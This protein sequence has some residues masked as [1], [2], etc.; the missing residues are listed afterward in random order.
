MQQEIDNLIHLSR[1]YGTNKDFVIASGGNS[2]FK[3]K[4]YLWITASGSFMGK[5]EESDLLK[6]S[7]EKLNEISSKT[8]NSDPQE[9]EKE[10]KN[11][12]VASIE[13]PG[14]SN[15]PSVE[16]SLHNLIEYSYIIHTHPTLV[17]GLLCSKQAEAKTK[18]LFQDKALYIEYTD[19]GYTLFKRI[20]QGIESYRQQHNHDP[21]L[22]F[23]QNHGLFV[24]AD[25]PNEIRQLYDEVM[26]SLEKQV[27][28]SPD[29]TE[30]P[31]NGNITDIL[32]AIRMM[33]SQDGLKVLKIRNNAL[34]ESY[35]QNEQAFKKISAPFTPDIIVF[36]KSHYLYINEEND[37]QK[38][39]QTFQKKLK[40]FQDAYGDIPKIILIKH[41]GIISVDEQARSAETV[42]DIYEDLIKISHYSEN[43]GGPNFM[44]KEQISFIENWEAEKYRHKLAKGTQQAASAK[45]QTAIVTGGSQG[46]GEGIV[47]RLFKKGINVVI[48]DIKEEKGKELVE[49]LNSEDIKNQIAFVQA[50]VSDDASME[51]CVYETVK[52]FGG[53]DL[54]ISNAGILKAGGLDEMDPDTFEAITRVNYKGYYISARQSSRVMKLQSEYHET[55]FTDIIQINSKSGLVGSKKNFTYAGSKFG[56]I[57][58]TQSF[59]LELIPYRIKVNSICPG[60]YFEGPLWSDPEEGLFVQYLKAGKVPGAKTIED[61]KKHYESRIP[62]GR[63]CQVDDLIKAV[64]YV[65]DQDY[66]TGQ[67]IPVTGGQAMLK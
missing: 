22:I 62:A 61:V 47:R 40:A 4:E 18:E 46:F 35:L 12:L 53:L 7:R 58:L 33:L 57:G 43:F 30:Q 38:I 48:A 28:S 64:Y 32:P 65:M 23:I 59:A 19:P 20:E 21:K 67:A 51:N 41:L 36:C 26:N 44:N 66:E 34:I 6:M 9:R 29:T 13:E 11:D 2:S 45:H 52:Q 14:T 5:L 17:N 39:L 54:M 56:G 42:L 1:Y 27:A 50:D 16:T 49:E 24:S 63:G 10:V 8:Y 31:V 60:N 55:H 37:P 25:T 3:T 15:R